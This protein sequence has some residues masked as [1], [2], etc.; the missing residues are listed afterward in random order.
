MESQSAPPGWYPDPSG[1][2]G[3]RYFDGAQWTEFFIDAPPQQRGGRSIRSIVI[4][5]IVGVLAVIGAV[6]AVTVR[7]GPPYDDASYHRGF[8]DG[9]D[10]LHSGTTPGVDFCRDGYETKLRA[11]ARNVKRDYIQ[12]CLDAGDHR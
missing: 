12:G 9:Q 8:H 10:A 6:L 4:T 1:R 7:T 3:Q 5:S 11:G 2:P